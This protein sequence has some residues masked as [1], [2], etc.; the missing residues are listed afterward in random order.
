MYSIGD[1]VD[2]LIIENVKIYNTRERIH[3]KEL[4]DDEYAELS[5]KMMIMNDNKTTITNMLNDKL[6]RVI[7]G[8]EKNR[9]LKIIKT[10]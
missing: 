6:E 2:K 8:E 1:M 9:L 5:N 3:T 10:F 4:D 7:S